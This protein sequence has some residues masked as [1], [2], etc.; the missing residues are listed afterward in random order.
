MDLFADEFA[1][2]PVYELVPRQ[3][4]FAGKFAGY[5]ERLEMRVVGAFDP[6]DR[7]IEAGLDQACDF[8]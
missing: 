1:K 5:D 2:C 4:P 8:S 7:A 6:D 3:R